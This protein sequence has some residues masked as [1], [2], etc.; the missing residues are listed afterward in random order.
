MSYEVT[1]GISGKGKKRAIT[2]LGFKTR[3]EAEKY[4]RETKDNYPGSNPRVV[5]VKGGK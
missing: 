1:A 2:N 4:V 5:K 3:R